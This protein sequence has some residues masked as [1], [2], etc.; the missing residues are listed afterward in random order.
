M[1]KSLLTTLLLITGISM[2]QDELP[3]V[4]QTTSF[5]AVITDTL[6][7]PIADGTRTFTFR[8]EKPTDTGS[9][10][11][12]WEETQEVEV[13]NGVISAVLG[14]VT[15]LNPIPFTGY[16]FQNTTY[17]LIISSDG[18]D[19]SVI[20]LTSVPFALN[21]SKTNYAAHAVDADHAVTA[22]TAHFVMATP[23]SDTSS[24]AHEAHHSV[25]TDTSGFTHQS[26]NST[27]ADTAHYMNLSSYNYFIRVVEEDDAS[28]KVFSTGD[29]SASYF[30]LISQT[31]DG[32]Q[33]ELR[34]VNEGNSGGDFRFYDATN[35]TDLMVLDTT[36][37]L[38]AS[39]FVGNGS[40]LT[41]I[42]ITN[43]GVTATAT[44][45]NIMDGVT[46]TTEEI[47]YVDGVTAAIQTQMDGKQPLDPDLTDLSDGTLSAS[48]VEHGSY[49]IPSP[50]DVGQVWTSDGSYAGHWLDPYGTTFSDLGLTATAAELNIMDGVTATNI[51]LNIIDG[52]TATTA[53]LNYVSGVSSAIQT[54]LDAKQALDAD[55]TDLAEDTLTSTKEENGIYFISSAGTDGYVWTSDGSGAGAWEVSASTV[56]GLSDALVEDNSIYIGNDPVS[57]TSSALK[58][59]AIGT[60]ALDAITGGDNNVAV[61][62][63]ALTANNSG[64]KNTALGY[65]AG[66]KI[67]T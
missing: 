27:Y 24:F 48:L 56:G 38:T 31:S 29:N 9:I 8:M 50:G 58:N 18:E 66:D 6:G 1:M 34:I 10:I 39:K 36:G 14:S 52:V 47:N 45:L 32:T 26:L 65:Q 51:E 17:N 12:I 2:A 59:V 49:F 3:T 33:R 22:D 13:V 44:E 15:P 53:E 43:F 37:S 19:I 63:D 60:T 30:G 55:L 11:E 35:N 57:T 25:Y 64:S 7:V 62:Y 42:T 5:Q 46:A 67:T 41:N 23:M 20:P 28:M 4:P 21:A 61:G 16:S 54:Q 40:E